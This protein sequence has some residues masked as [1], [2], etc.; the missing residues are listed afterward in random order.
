MNMH[1]VAQPRYRGVAAPAI[2]AQGFRPFFLAAAAWSAGALAVWLHMLTGGSALPSLFPPLAWHVHEMLYGFVAATV[3]GF[4]LTAIPNWTGRMPL[5]GGPLLMLVLLWVAGRA[6]VAM[7][8]HIGGATAAVIDLAFLDAL[9]VFVSREVIAGRNWRNLP[10]PIALLVLLVG[11]GLMHAEAIGWIAES[12]IGWRVGLAVFVMLISL[13]GGRIIPSFTRNWLAKRGPGS[14]PAPFGVPDK[15][16]LAVTGV[17]MALWVALPDGHVTGAALLLAAVLQGIRLA[18]WRGH[19]TLAE[20]L[21]WI[22][23]LAYAWLPAG[24]GLLGAAAWVAEVPATMAIHALTAGAI[25]TI[26]LAVMTRATLGHTGRALHADTAT[27]AIYL[28]VTVAALARL[29]AAV[30]TEHMLP[31]LTIS[32]ACWIGAFGG[33]ALKYGYYLIRPRLTAGT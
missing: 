5:E 9:L 27:T 3:A 21:V 14:M 17:A 15:L 2:L 29:A 16:A 23:H 22:L 24:M 32:G 1:R 7:S 28:S 26:T 20:P 4:L 8:A 33:F 25:G 11:N 10:M 13:I 18:R 12:G 30:C 31:L 6:A 19:R